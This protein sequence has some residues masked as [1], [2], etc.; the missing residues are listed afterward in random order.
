M[1]CEDYYADEIAQEKNGQSNSTFY[2]DTYGY[3][4]NSQWICPNLEKSIITDQPV[5]NF[6]HTVYSCHDA[7]MFDTDFEPKKRCLA[8]SEIQEQM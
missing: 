8:N 2:S 3:D 4:G 6:Q 1:N 7:K 5:N